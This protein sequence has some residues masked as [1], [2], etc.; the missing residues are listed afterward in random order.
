MRTYKHVK[1][2]IDK[3]KKALVVFTHGAHFDYDPSGNGQIGKWHVNPSVV[4]TVDQVIVY[5]RE[6]D[7]ENRIFLGNYKGIEESG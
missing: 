7:G 2:V 3:N 6:A 4:E 5:K 1:E